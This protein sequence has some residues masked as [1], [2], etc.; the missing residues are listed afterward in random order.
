MLLNSVAS[1]VQQIITLIC[2][3]IVPQMILS[4]YGSAVNGT[5]AS[6]TQFISVTS[7]IQGGVTS[8]T[9][10]ALYKP[11]A[12][13]NIEDASIVYRTSQKFFSVFSGIL[14][15]YV[16][17]LAIVYPLI[18]HV[19]F[20]YSD[21]LI[22]IIIIG[23]GLVLEYLLGVTNQ[24]IL[25][26]D[27]LGFI[28]TYLSSAGT[29]L[30]AVCSIVLIKMGYGIIA[31]K[32]LAAICL[33]LR[34]IIL[35]IIVSRKYKLNLKAK[36]DK[37]VLSQSNAALTKSIAYSVHNNT[38]NLVITAFLNVMWVSVYSVHKYVVWSISTLV[39]TVLGNTEVVFGQLLAKNDL[40][41]LNKELPIYDLLAKLGTNIFFTTC[42]ILI[43]EFVRIYTH[44]ITDINYHHPLFATLLSISEA[45][46]CSSLTYHNMI[47]GGGHIKQTQWISI[48]EAILNL[49]LSVILVKTIGINGV[50]IGT[51]FAFSFTTVAEITYMKKNIFDLDTMFIIK[52]YIL[53]I[54]LSIILV[55]AFSNAI[56]WVPNNY[57]QFFAY[58]IV[59]FGIV[60]I[61]VLGV[62]ALLFKEYFG[63][64]MKKV[65][66]KH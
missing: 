2:G 7:L 40:K 11:M 24:L 31:V 26:A 39:S 8:A 22:L 4:A 23:A 15:V 30:N 47:M 59:V 44:G 13:N 61:V 64:I 41:A 51:I 58:A 42:I 53:N 9:R 36:T 45:V 20:S 62:H 33:M 65:I 18:F 19:P 32:F 37:S 56:G 57:F 60:C 25:F 5:I 29:L 54:V 34:P 38:D 14:F 10:V 52:E 1:I 21:A 46:Y 66:R 27:Q 55:F 50:V 3:L 12:D 35:K 63:N 28:N 49:G 48:V 16:I 6:V 43:N 17:I